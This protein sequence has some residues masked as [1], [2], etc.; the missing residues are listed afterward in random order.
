MIIG[1]INDYF[2]KIDRQKTDDI[3]LQNER[4]CFSNA[5]VFSVLIIDQSFGILGS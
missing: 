1:D 5:L 4:I 3:I 2:K